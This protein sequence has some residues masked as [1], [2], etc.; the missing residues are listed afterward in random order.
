MKVL[1]L[2][3][4]A[5]ANFSFG[6]YSDEYSAFFR[7]IDTSVKLPPQFKQETRQTKL[8]FLRKMYEDTSSTLCAGKLYAENFAE[9]V[10]RYDTTLY[11]HDFDLDGDYDILF[12]GRLC[13]GHE[14]TDAVLF[15]KIG[16]EYIS[17]RLGNWI[18]KMELSRKRKELVVLKTPCCA[19]FQMEFMYY[20]S[21][22]GVR[23]SIRQHSHQI[24]YADHFE[25][26]PATID[27]MLTIEKEMPVIMSPDLTAEDYGLYAQIGPNPEI[28]TLKSG[29]KIKVYNTVIYN[30]KRWYYI[31]AK[32]DSEIMLNEDW[33]QDYFGNI[34]AA[35]GWICLE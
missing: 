28:G 12:F 1:L 19:D 25:T 32:A 22:D 8:R 23:D 35:R 33:S 3:F 17:Q 34:K 6:Q 10:N 27:T 7:E 16:R 26:A 18:I 2:F 20:E 24:F 30:G 15:F 5:I 21:M 29:L 11:V 4:L 9:F 13:P 31:I 14:N